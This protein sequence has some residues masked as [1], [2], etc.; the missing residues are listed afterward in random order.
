MLFL[1]KDLSWV[2][3]EERLAWGSPP[4]ATEECCWACW[5]SKLVLAI[6]ITRMKVAYVLQP[7]PLHDL[8]KKLGRPG[9]SSCWLVTKGMG[10]RLWSMH[11]NFSLLKEET[12]HFA[13]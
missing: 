3:P 10:V 13:Y 1:A 5:T 12:K 7:G 2:S 9:P 11:F 6:R 8:W 4:R